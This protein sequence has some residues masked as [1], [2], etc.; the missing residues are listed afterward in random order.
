MLA[1]RDADFEDFVVKGGILVA[2][3]CLCLSLWGTFALFNWAI[4]HLIVGGLVWG[5]SHLLWDR[6]S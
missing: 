2:G 3:V 5:L 6:L 4:F 1:A